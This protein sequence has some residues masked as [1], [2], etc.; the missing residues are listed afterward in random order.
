M[1]SLSLL[2]Y[3]HLGLAVLS[4]YNTNEHTKKCKLNF[5]E[6]ISYY[7]NFYEVLFKASIVDDYASVAL[8]L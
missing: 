8:S 3:P 4:S 1:D 5:I 6:H 2:S 7:Q